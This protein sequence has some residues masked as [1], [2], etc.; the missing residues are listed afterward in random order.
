AG[1]ECRDQTIRIHLW[2]PA[3]G[4]EVAAGRPIAQ[5]GDWSPA[6][7]YSPDSKYLAVGGSEGV[8]H[9]WDVAARKEARR[10]SSQRGLITALASAPAGRTVAAVT[11]EHLLGIPR[12]TG[13]GDRVIRLWDIATGDVRHKIDGPVGGSRCVAWSPDGRTLATGG[14]DGRV[15]L[16]E[17]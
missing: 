12:S 11:A 14:D 15:R 8:I 9:L 4:K 3:T 5:P 7:S 10:I 16:W 17:V 6:L 13:R 1:T 2:D